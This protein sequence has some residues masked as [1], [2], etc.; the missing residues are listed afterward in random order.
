M[1]YDIGRAI[2]EGHTYLGIKLGSTRISAVLIGPDCKP[3]ASGSQSWESRLENGIWTYDIDDVWAG[4]EVCFARLNSELKS[5]YGLPLTTTGC[6][7]VSAIMHGYLPLDRDKQPL[8]PFRT[9]RNTVAE[10][11]AERLSE[12]LQVNIAQRWSIAHLY[13]AILNGEVH[14]Y[15]IAHLTTLAGYVHERL[16]G[17]IVLGAGDASGMFPLDGLAYDARMMDVF[18]GLTAEYNLNWKLNDILPRVLGAGADAGSLTP[19]GAR[20]LDITGQLQPNISFCPP[21]GDTSTGRGSVT[22]V[23]ERAGSVSAGTSIYASVVLERPLSKPHPEIEIIATPT[24]KPAAMVHCYN[25]MSDLE[26]WIALFRQVIEITG[27]TVSHSALYNAFYQKATEGDADGGG[28]LS[29]N[30]VSGEPMTGLNE[31][32][33]LFVRLPDSQLTLANFARTLLYSS[34][35]TLRHGIDVLTGEQVK[36]DRM[37]GHGGVFKSEEGL[38]LMAVA[39]NVPVTVMSSSTEGEAWGAALLAAYHSMKISGE[40]LED[41]LTKRVFADLPSRSAEPDADDKDGFAVYMERFKNGMA[42]E[43][44][45][46]ENLRQF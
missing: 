46:V 36:L 26:A 37:V 25:C 24:G 33:P 30:Y 2:E 38:K 6:I 4:L 1:D 18:D 23:A 12:A 11:A 21:E 19:E 15:D 41:F 7:G 34:V 45:A 9:W 10:K 14:I 29:Y 40:T 22:C 43:R 17:H 39:L 31:G 28:L 44:A 16:T 32:R 5:S 20:L 3:I 8:T 35:A 13:Q 27:A 42:I